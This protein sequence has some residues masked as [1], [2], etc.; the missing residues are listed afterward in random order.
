V[1]CLVSMLVGV[2]LSFFLDSASAPTIVLVLTAIFLAAF[3]YRVITTA[4]RSGEMASKEYS[5]A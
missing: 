4:R 5:S 1:V 2:Y 3:I